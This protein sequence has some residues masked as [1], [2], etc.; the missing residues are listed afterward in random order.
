MDITTKEHSK[1]MAE[2]QKAIGDLQNRYASTKRDKNKSSHHHGN[3]SI[4]QNQ[5]EKHH[6]N[7]IS[8]S[9]N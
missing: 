5:F 3:M 8:K 1:K 6:N 2:S 4:S 7:H 9:V